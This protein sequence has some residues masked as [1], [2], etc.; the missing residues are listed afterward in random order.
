MTLNANW[1]YPTAIRFGAGRISEIADACFVAGIK[2]PLLVTDR[3]LAGMEITQKTLNLLDD[4][5]L[6]RAIFA[7]V[8]PNPNE[9]N[10]AAGVAAYKAGNHDGVIAFGGGSGLDLGKV[11][12]F[13]AG[14][15]RPIWDFEDIDDWW[16]RANSDVIAPIVAIPTTA[17]TGSEVGRASVIT[18][19]I[20]QQKKI[21]FH[22]KFLP[23]VVICD[24][25]LTV[26][27]PKFIT[28][29][30]G[31]DAFAHC[32][33]AY[34]S[35]HYHP[36][37]QGMALEG[38]RLVKEYLPRAYSDA[39]DLEA[40]SHMMSAAAMGATAFQKG[41]GAIHAL[42]HPIGAI[43]H[44]HHGTTNAVCMPA[45]LKFNKPAIK[46]TLAEAAN[47]LSISG[48]FDGFCKFVD[49]LNDSLAIPKSLAGLGI[50]NPDIDRIVSGALIDPS[51]GGNPIKMTEENTRKLI[52]EIS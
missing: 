16:T 35:P 6:G 10:A 1:S 5:G 14:Q 45:V 17:G 28:A 2:K 15:S 18:N 26:G 51:T 36:M 50:E 23:T 12:A 34:C 31:L 24:P 19:S 9:K 11:V 40:R 47:Y 44:T 52:I 30:T 48:G 41:L 33:E 32:V 8:D 22:P 49:E 20:T 25:E 4:A 3:G 42:S 7:D 21:I 39:T 29:G 43:Y 27:M 38:M 13:L 46:D 37:S